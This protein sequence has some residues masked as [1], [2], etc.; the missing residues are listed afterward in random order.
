MGKFFDMRGLLQAV[1]AILAA[2]YLAGLLSSLTDGYGEWLQTVI[3][4]VIG[5]GVFYL[6]DFMVSAILRRQ[7]QADKPD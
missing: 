2:L 7:G 4:L 6:L 5:V 3:K 1:V